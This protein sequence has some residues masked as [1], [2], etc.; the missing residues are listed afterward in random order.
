MRECFSDKSFLCGTS[1]AERPASNV[2]FR[3]ER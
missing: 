2:E 3:V 1:N